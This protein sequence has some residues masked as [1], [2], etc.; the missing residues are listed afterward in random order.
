MYWGLDYPPLAA[1]HSFINGL[2]ANYINPTWVK[3]NNSRGFEGYHHKIFMRTSV[4]LSDIIIYFTSTILFWITLNSSRPRIKAMCITLFLLYPGLILIDHGHFQYNCI[5]LGLTLWSIVFMMHSK[6][7]LAS[8]AFCLALNYKQMSLYHALPFF[9]Y[10]LGLSFSQSSFFTQ[11]RKLFT[12]SVTVIVTFAIV[13][14]PFIHDRQTFNSVVERL[15]PFNR[16][17]YEVCLLFTF[18]SYVMQNLTS[19]SLSGQSRQRLVFT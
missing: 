14:L 5:N 9:F 8:I 12:I 4:L 7:L 16:G 1:Y 10:L 3:L 2:I 17:L 6:H 13:W 18:F 15:F 11:L 19:S